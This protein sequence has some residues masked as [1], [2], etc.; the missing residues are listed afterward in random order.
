[1]LPLP[2]AL[3][4]QAAPI[5]DMVR[6]TKAEAEAT[7]EQ[8]LDAAERVFA[9]QGVARTSLQQVADAAG[10][11]RGAIYWHF[12]HKADLFNAMMERVR[13]P[14]EGLSPPAGCAALRAAR[15]L[16]L[17]ALGRVVDEPQVQRVVEIA[18]FKVEYTDELT[19]VAE[20]H[21]RVVSE[22]QAEL[23][24]LLREAGLTDAAARHH[25]VALHALVVGLIQTWLLTQRGF[26]LKAEGR[27]AL[28]TYL[29]G[30]R[31]TAG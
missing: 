19:Q 13:L 15:D 10:L 31:P 24:R 18:L 16:L 3:V 11:T 17:H 28:D 8:L 6:R 14:L 30:L 1:M 29:A 5:H 7:R 21:R 26:D 20:R 25:A 2:C 4:C 9:A 12:Q 23:G 22:L 27:C